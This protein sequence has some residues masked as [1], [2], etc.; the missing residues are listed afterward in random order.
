MWGE[1]KRH[2]IGQTSISCRPWL[3]EMALP[4]HTVLFT[5]EQ[6][7]AFPQGSHIFLSDVYDLINYTVF[8]QPFINSIMYLTRNFQNFFHPISF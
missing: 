2:G 3:N 5:V 4:I 8:Q 1:G 7:Q 6:Q